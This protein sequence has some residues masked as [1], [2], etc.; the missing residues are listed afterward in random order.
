MQNNT[1]NLLSTDKKQEFAAV[2]ALSKKYP[3]IKEIYN[4]LLSHDEAVRKWIN[5]SS[6][7]KK[8]FFKNPVKA[9]RLVPDISRTDYNELVDKISSLNSSTHGEE[10]CDGTSDYNP[11]SKA[12]TNGWD[13][14][15]DAHLKQINDAFTKYFK[16]NKEDTLPIKV[17]N[18]EFAHFNV[19]MSYCVSS[20]NIT[21]AV[22]GY[23][24]MEI[25]MPY[26][27]INAKYAG[28]ILSIDDIQPW[29]MDLTLN[30]V[31]IEATIKLAEVH[32]RTESG[33]EKI[34]VQISIENDSTSEDDSTIKIDSFTADKPDNIGYFTWQGIQSCVAKLLTK[35]LG[36]ATCDNP[37]TIF[38][39]LISSEQQN[40]YNWAIPKEMRFSGAEASSQVIDDYFIGVYA[41]T[42][43]DITD[44]LAITIDSEI[45][46]KSD[47]AI[48][49][50]SQ[51]IA[52]QN[53]FTPAINA[54]IDKILNNSKENN[55]FY[56][57]SNS[58]SIRSAV[59]Y[60]ISSE[61]AGDME[62]YDSEFKMIDDGFH[63]ETKFSTTQYLMN[64]EGT[65]KCNLYAQVSCT[66]EQSVT[67]EFGIT[68]PEVEVEASP[69]WIMWVLICI[70]IVGMLALSFTAIFRGLADKL[71]D[72]CLS[73]ATFSVDI[74]I[75]WK[76]ISI[77][78]IA[79]IRI[80]DGLLIRFKT[81]S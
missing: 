19:Q 79:D 57:D 77:E 44:N 66:E 30:N 37:Y 7:N 54:G 21:K 36:K 73:P 32:L 16:Y 60:V 29:N 45:A 50:L 35:I 62:L 3:Q 33:Q 5:Q 58:K 64:C 49:A 72:I 9:L 65:M 43:N 26:C 75:D 42:I 13:M 63:F 10:F 40:K 55:I 27:S 34:D 69:S 23:V 80:S 17:S 31:T 59:K 48:V 81:S 39:V 4:C 46:P 41:Q 71:V 78:N 15:S 2:E 53:I 74:P 47:E 70:P 24:T 12:F 28:P 67:I 18:N 76:N 22:G 25:S 56:Y 8:L 51:E 20:M 11:P 61:E 1:F 52:A 6:S 14:I 38:S 68:E